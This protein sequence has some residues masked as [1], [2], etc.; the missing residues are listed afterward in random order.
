[1]S[2]ATTFARA[3]LPAAVMVAPAAAPAA[4]PADLAKIEAHLGSVDTMTA[5]FTQTD[6]KGQTL[7]GTL[8]LKR[9]GRIRFEYGRG[10]DVLV[11][12]NGKTL[13]FVD[14]EVGQKSSWQLNKTPLGILLS[15]NPDIKRIARIVDDKDPRVLVVRAQDPYHKE[16]GTLILAFIRE[17]SAPGGL[18][19]Y[20]WTAVDA[21]G[22]RTQVRLSNQR[23]NV[24]VSP[25]A[26]TYAEP[27]KKRG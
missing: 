3:L 13:T 23:Y 15:S 10:V 2:L 12:A 1:M 18:K 16:Y 26:F 8:Q 6:S 22:K 14:Y 21:Q 27:K 25:N 19:L 5:N 7:T 9:P 11:V 24:A 4:N 17:A 20:G